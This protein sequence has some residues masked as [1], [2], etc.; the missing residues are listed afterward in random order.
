MSRNGTD[1]QATRTGNCMAEMTKVIY[2]KVGAYRYYG[3]QSAYGSFFLS[4]FGVAHAPFA[5][6]R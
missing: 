3:F 2:V 4:Y 1:R 6:Q 5:C